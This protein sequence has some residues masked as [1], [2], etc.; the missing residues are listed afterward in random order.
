MFGQFKALSEAYMNL[1]FSQR[2]RAGCLAVRKQAACVIEGCKAEKAEIY[3][4]GPKV[5]GARQR[6][7]LD[8]LDVWQGKAE[9]IFDNVNDMLTLAE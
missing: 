4:N 8:L 1:R 6:S 2:T 3:T 5:H 9:A 7:R